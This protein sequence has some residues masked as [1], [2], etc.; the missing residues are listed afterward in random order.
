MAIIDLQLPA[1]GEGIIEATILK[2]HK[3]PGDRI[4]EDDTVVDIAT[5]K[6]DSE[7]PANASGILKEIFFGENQVAP[8]G[9]VLATIETEGS[10][11]EDISP[12][13]NLSE[14]V[15][16][17]YV[18]PQETGTTT[19]AGSNGANNGFYSPLVVNMAKTEG[20]AFSELETIRG[21]GK[22]GRL[23]KEDLQQYIAGK[24]TAVAP[25]NTK[26]SAPA[27]PEATEKETFIPAGNV[28]IIEM[29]R[30][31]RLIAQN[32]KDSQNISATVTSFAEVDVTNI[33][34]WREKIKKAFE[35]QENT[36]I[37]FTPIFIDGIIKVIKRFPLINSSVNG[38]KIIVKKDINIGLATA[39]PSG[40]LIVPVIK[41]AAYLNLAGLSR[42]VNTL[43]DKA[44]SN[45]LS[46]ADTQEGT[47]T[48]TNV[49]SFG[50]LTGTPIINQP[51]VAILAIGTIKKRPVVIET[52]TGDTIGIRHMMILSMSYDH[53]I[54]DGALGSTFLGEVVKEMENWDLNK[55]I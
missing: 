23:T 48:V 11:G 10:N 7:V 39:L 42:A 35:K 37:T 13:D 27:Q 31:R 17:P 49:G 40:N 54:I 15:D 21:S 51:Q 25:A 16:V 6:V 34:Q 26:N 32:M 14:T 46:P 9:G 38:D 55:E 43:A 18:P 4:E 41:N 1:L 33:V 28:D 45:K 2:W 3:K 50:S 53:R 30:M 29:D 47:F 5:D 36:K 12:K 19:T 24:K 52:A 22:D 20:I 8:V 44:R